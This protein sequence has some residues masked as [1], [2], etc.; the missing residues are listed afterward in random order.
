LATE[1]LAQ[2]VAWASGLSIE[3]ASVS[4]VVEGSNPEEPHSPQLP[5]L[6]AASPETSFE[7]RGRKGLE[8][9]FSDSAFLG[10]PGMETYRDTV[11]SDS[12]AQ[13]EHSAAEDADGDETE[14]SDGDAFLS[15]TSLIATTKKLSLGN[16][17]KS[18]NAKNR[19]EVREKFIGRKDPNNKTESKRASSTRSD[20]TR[21][22]VS[23][24]DESDVGRASEVHLSN[25]PLLPEYG[26]GKEGSCEETEMFTPTQTTKEQQ[27]LEE[28]EIKETEDEE[29]FFFEPGTPLFPLSDSSDVEVNTTR[30]VPP[31]P[32]NTPFLGQD[33]TAHPPLPSAA[34]LSPMF[35]RSSAI[36]SPTANCRHERTRSPSSP[37]FRRGSVVYTPTDKPSFRRSSVLYSPESKAERSP[38]RTPPRT[39]PLRAKPPK[40]EV[41][42][43]TKSRIE[44]ESPLVGACYDFPSVQ[45]GIHLGAMTVQPKPRKPSY[46]QSRRLIAVVD[47]NVL[48]AN[49]TLVENMKNY[50]SVTLVIPTAVVRELDGLKVGRGQTAKG[51]RVAIHSLRKLLEET[52]STLRFQTID[53]VPRSYSH[54]GHTRSNDDR[55]LDCC[56]FYAEM[57][58]EEDQKVILLTNDVALQVKAESFGRVPN[59][60]GHPVSA[61]G[62][63]AFYEKE[64]WRAV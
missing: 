40:T 49:L 18:R 44:R 21:Q 6:E 3:E 20:S 7:G 58:Q 17:R 41:V 13:N 11:G 54:R 31:A 1:S 22:S 51:A 32:P 10:L 4:G 16:E 30:K 57:E 62:V 63:R 15:L 29:L 9:Q 61:M 46:F 64:V 45:S 36:Y 26:S 5:E 24:F 43:K 48:L 35:R 19:G 27:E 60:S 52:R 14:D 56:L 28:G 34:P 25:F 23:E 42:Q 55:I 50:P 33:S 37:V 12:E 8:C 53:E 47:T 2:S 59:K 38:P 39:T